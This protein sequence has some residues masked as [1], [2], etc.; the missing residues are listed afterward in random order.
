MDR[1]LV[2]SLTLTL[3]LAGSSPALAA[4]L[5]VDSTQDS[6]D[7]KPGDGQCLSKAGGCTLRAAIEEAN[8]TTL[9]DTVNVPPGTYVLTVPSGGGPDFAQTGTL[10]LNGEIQILGGDAANTIIDGG[11]KLRVFETENDST[12]SLMGLTIQNGLAEG[13]NGG[14][15][16][17]RGHLKLADVTVK[18]NRAKGDPLNQSGGGGGIMNET[19]GTATL[20]NVRVE[21]NTADGR[22]GGIRN[23]GEMQVMNSTIA[24]NASLTDDAGG[25]YNEGVLS[26]LL[27]EVDGNRAQNGAGIDN[28]KGQVKITDS[29]L[30]GNQA[31][32]DGGALYNSGT[33]T[34][35]NSTFSGNSASSSGGAI[36]NRAEGSVSLNNVTIAGNK[37]GSGAQGGGIMNEATATVT[38]ANTIVAGNSAGSGADCSGPVTSGGYNLI[39]SDGGCTITGDVAGNVIG[40][41]AQ[42]AVLAKNDGP[43]RTQL[44]QP[45][46]PAIDAGN[47]AT[48]TGSGNTCARADQ[49][50]V[51]RDQAGR[52]DIGAAEVSTAA[53]ASH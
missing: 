2:S 17:N 20:M 37:A 35:V 49:R 4:N 16:L 25:I 44:P 50:G 23:V 7:A 38:I 26:L 43:T 48:A 34:A 6:P 39:Q 12:I 32:A 45:G 9:S 33:V 31:S 47:P 21:G 11:G 29:T 10:T 14:A 1:S 5:N 3:L 42:L 28:V 30:A 22:G 52:C 41:D 36:A 46:S 15:I 40:K 51:A 24:G 8:A 27:S 53:P 18:N 19:S 13:G